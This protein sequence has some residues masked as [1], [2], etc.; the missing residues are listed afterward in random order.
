MSD[1]K[2]GN[3]PYG[4]ERKPWRETLAA[5][6]VTPKGKLLVSPPSRDPLLEYAGVASKVTGS[7]YQVPSVKLKP[8]QQDQAQ[9]ETL[10]VLGT[11][12]ENF[13]GY[14]ADQLMPNYPELLK[15]YLGFHSN[16]VGDPFTAGTFTVNTKWMECNVLDYYASLWNGKWPYKLEDPETY[17]LGLRPDHGLNRRKLLCCLER[18][19]LPF[20]YIIMKALECRTLAAS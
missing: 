14:Q 6:A 20:R 12:V 13:V 1:S 15:P 18:T 3:I 16:N 7:F 11:Q 17:I 5:V 9:Q 19:G 2:G 8:D 10:N 4:P